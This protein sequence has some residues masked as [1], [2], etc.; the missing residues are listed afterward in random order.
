MSTTLAITVD[1]PKG[2]LIFS[3]VVVLGSEYDLTWAGAG[4]ATPTLVLT[5]PITDEI[6]AVSVA[7][8]L[9]LN[10]IALINLFTDSYKR[11]RT[12]WAYAYADSVV[13]GSGHV[14]LEYSPLSFESGPD[15]ELVTGLSD[16]IT[17]HVANVLNPHQVTL[18]QVGAA[19]ASHTHNIGDLKFQMPDSKWYKFVFV[20]AGG[21]PTFQFEETT[22]P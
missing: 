2:K 18:A 17:A 4:L 6:L 10:T 19:A 11:P 9:K 15:P 22:E 14:I 5:N 7:D 1:E 20:Y 13:L 8:E 21:Q 16:R 12:I 3:R